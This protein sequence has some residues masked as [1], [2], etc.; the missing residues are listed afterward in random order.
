MRPISIPIR[1]CR[2]ADCRAELKHWPQP[3]GSKIGMH[4]HRSFAQVGPARSL[5]HENIYREVN[6]SH[7]ADRS[8]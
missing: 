7:A 1:C 6:S 3:K 5:C 2:V 8:A 4:V